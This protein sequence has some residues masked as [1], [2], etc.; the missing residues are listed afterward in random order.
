MPVKIEYEKIYDYFYF[1]IKFNFYMLAMNNLN[2]VRI[3]L[4]YL[5]LRIA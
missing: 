2:V 5:F 4:I 3:Y 1:L